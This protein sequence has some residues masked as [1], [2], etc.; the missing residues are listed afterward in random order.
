MTYEELIGEF[1]QIEFGLR[2]SQV[3]KMTDEIVLDDTIIYGIERIVEK[4]KEDAWQRR[5]K[6]TEVVFVVQHEG[7]F[8]DGKMMEYIGRF[9]H[10][11]VSY[12]S[13]PEGG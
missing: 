5:Q 10:H 11:I 1:D 7:E 2:N 3:V 9:G 8:D 12:G 13:G 6:Y 4:I